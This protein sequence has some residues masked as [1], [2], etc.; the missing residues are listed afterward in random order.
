MTAVGF[1][2]K[3]VVQ[4]VF[5]FFKMNKYHFSLNK[6]EVRINL[7]SGAKQSQKN[8]LRSLL[9]TVPTKSVESFM[10]R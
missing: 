5:F 3:H 6:A 2:Q 4:S 1:L 8:N 10:E 9:S 7:Q